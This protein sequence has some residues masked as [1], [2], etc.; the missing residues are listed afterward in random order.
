M[1]NYE[2]FG[3][4]H[5]IYG[6]WRFGFNSSVER[7]QQKKNTHHGESGMPQIGTIKVTFSNVNLVFSYIKVD[8][9]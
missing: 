8:Q 2:V 1:A 6:F 7:C 4:W 9:N 5:S 3:A